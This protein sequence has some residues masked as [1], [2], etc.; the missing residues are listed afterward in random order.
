MI[1]PLSGLDPL[2]PATTLSK[3]VKYIY[4]APPPLF[5]PPPPP[6]VFYFNAIGGG[7]GGG[8]YSFTFNDGSSVNVTYSEY[9]GGFP[10]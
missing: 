6:P 8:S 2:A 4:V 7:G 9:A 3:T 1:D 5:P 10:L